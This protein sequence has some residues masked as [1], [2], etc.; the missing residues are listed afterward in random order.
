MKI[1]VLSNKKNACRV[2]VVLIAKKSH[3]HSFYHA[4][5]PD[6][7]R[8]RSITSSFPLSYPIIYEQLSS[9]IEI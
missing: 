7:L 4:S 8:H 3:F 5:T 9:V 6:K 1:T 2:T